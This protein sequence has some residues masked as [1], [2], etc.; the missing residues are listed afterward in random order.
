MR[1]SLY[2]WIPFAICLA[3]G[4]AGMGRISFKLIE[5]DRARAEQQRQD[6]VEERARLALWRMDSSLATLIAIENARPYFAYSAFFP[7]ERAYTQMFSEY[8]YG[9]VLVP[10][11]LLRPTSP[12]ILLHFQVDSDGTV[13]SPQVPHDRVRKLAVERQYV[14]VEQVEAAGKR[15]ADATPM[16]TGSAL[17]AQSFPN[18][19]SVFNPAQTAGNNATINFNG[20]FALGNNDLNLQAGQHATWDDQPGQWQ[21]KL[22]VQEQQSRANIKTQTANTAYMAQRNPSI[23]QL[24]L[25]SINEGVMTPVWVD[26]HLLL[27]RRVTISPREYVQGCLFDWPAMKRWLLEGVAD[28]LP[29]ADLEPVRDADG[30]QP[31]LLASLPLRM[32]VGQVPYEP[33][34]GDPSL[35]LML[36]VA[37]TGLLLAS[38][39]VAA[40]LAGVMALSERRGAF[41]SAVTHEL[42]TPLTTL[43]MYS[44]MLT[45]GTVTDEDRRQ[46]YLVTLRSEANRLG[47]L[48]ENVLAYSRLERRRNGGKLEDTTVGQLLERITGRLAERAQHGG[49]ALEVQVPEALAERKLHTDPLA[50]EQILFNLVDNACKYAASA[51]DKRI[52]VD[53]SEAGRCIE[54][55][56][57]D[58]GPGMPAKTRG[59]LFRPFSKSVQEAAVT[60]PGLGLGLALCKRLA[61]RIGGDLRVCED[62]PAGACVALIVPPER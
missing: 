37:W 6:Q 15:L 61:R 4:L 30:P 9:D 38:A 16:L 26:E 14:S 21:Q 43:R 28:L 35:R 18:Q 50:V 62:A 52:H 45:S 41:V 54:V 24:P 27:V 17:L 29:S 31:R 2:I 11:P 51:A 59:R 47:H 48:V 23:G 58:H 42:R 56:V 60:A 36:T 8:R 13:S 39:A 3:V 19:W 22:S 7:A 55:R 25:G 12:L 20:G 10:S 34:S 46:R 57:R 1:R 49:M 33:V 44:E 5:L 53:V 32:V 40:L